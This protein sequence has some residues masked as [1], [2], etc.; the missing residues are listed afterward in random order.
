[1][2]KGSFKLKD[3]VTKSE[4]LFQR[5]PLKFMKTDSGKVT[6]SES[7]LNGLETDFSLKGVQL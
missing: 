6:C 4:L 7:R 2:V 1:M 3:I 5:L